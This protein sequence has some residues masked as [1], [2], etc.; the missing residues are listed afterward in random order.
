MT[1]TARLALGPYYECPVCYRWAPWTDG[2]V[3]AVGDERD[4]FWCQTCGEET[5]LDLMRVDND[6]GPDALY[7]AGWGS[8]P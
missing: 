4:E 2:T 8:N 1:D 7:G 6:P 5:P 3:K